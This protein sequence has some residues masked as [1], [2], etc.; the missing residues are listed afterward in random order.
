M[1]M[2]QQSTRGKL[3]YLPPCLSVFKDKQ[4]WLRREFIPG[5]GEPA[6]LTAAMLAGR[7]RLV[8]VH[9]V[10]QAWMPTHKGRREKIWLAA[11]LSHESWFPPLRLTP[12]LCNE[13]AAVTGLP[14]PRH[15]V[16][17]LVWLLPRRV[18]KGRQLI[19]VVHGS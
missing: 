19:Q 15:W 13:F 2:K 10:E 11:L 3:L 5:E 8:A 14:H 7:P 9:Y 12:R 4:I 1:S 6:W 16:G 17:Q 18:G